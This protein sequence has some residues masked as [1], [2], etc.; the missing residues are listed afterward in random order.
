MEMDH[1]DNIPG[2]PRWWDHPPQRCWNK[3]RM[4]TTFS[5]LEQMNG[6]DWGGSRI[7]A[8]DRGCGAA[9][10]STA[11]VRWGPRQTARRQPR[12]E[13]TPSPEGRA[14]TTPSFWGNPTHRP[15]APSCRQR[16][17]MCEI[18]PVRYAVGNYMRHQGEV[19]ST[20]CRISLP[21]KMW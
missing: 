1:D 13:Y 19:L 15:C 8:V 3:G 5:G 7:Q 17:I 16:K 10:H 12:R 11:G 21:W 9:G 14:Q 6:T 4:D 18:L 2:I 20:A